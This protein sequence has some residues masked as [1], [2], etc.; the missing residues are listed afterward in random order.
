MFLGGIAKSYRHDFSLLDDKAQRGKS[1]RTLEAL[2]N[3]VQGIINI[4]EVVDIG[5]RDAKKGTEASTY[6]ENFFNTI[7]SISSGDNSNS[8]EAVQNFAN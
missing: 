2:Q 6:L 3:T 1:G 8:E 7:R 4:I 5:T